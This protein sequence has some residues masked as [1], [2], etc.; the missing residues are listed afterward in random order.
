VL[1]RVFQRARA[2]MA[3]PGRRFCALALVAQAGPA[4]KADGGAALA[5]AAVL[6]VVLVA[7]VVLPAVWSV[8]PARRRAALAVLDRLVRW[9]GH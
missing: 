6:L 4:V 3:A 7:G 8:K 1:N 9:K 2:L 5:V